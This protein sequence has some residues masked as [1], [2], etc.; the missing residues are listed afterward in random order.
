MHSQI[1]AARC[2]ARSLRLELLRL[3]GLNGGANN[4]PRSPPYASV[5]QD[6]CDGLV[7]VALIP[8]GESAMPAGPLRA[9]MFGARTHLWS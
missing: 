2:G 3:L 1:A 9:V 4:P 5:A 6:T 8:P 7:H